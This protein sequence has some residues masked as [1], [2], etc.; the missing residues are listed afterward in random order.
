MV[1][2]EKI[3]DEYVVIR[4]NNDILFRSTKESSCKDWIVEYNEYNRNLI[5]RLRNK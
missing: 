1:A 2:L 4:N 5:L 3:G